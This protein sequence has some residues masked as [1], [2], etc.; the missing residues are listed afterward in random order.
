MFKKIVLIVL[1]VVLASYQAAF[2]CSG[3]GDNK[4]VG[5]VT[6][7]NEQSKTFTIMDMEQR[8]PIIFSA[9]AE[10]LEKANS[11]SSVIT[12]TFEEKDGQLVAVEIGG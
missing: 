11:A 12:V 5:R 2:A 3:A 1:I 4:H 6:A 8:K 7:V 10:L 9:A